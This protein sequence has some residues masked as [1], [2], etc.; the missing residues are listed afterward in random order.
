[1]AQK[2]IKRTN[3]R[4]RRTAALSVV[5]ADGPTTAADRFSPEANYWMAGQSFTRLIRRSKKLVPVVLAAATLTGVIWL[6]PT[7]AETLR[8]QAIAPTV[9]GSQTPLPAA[10][11]GAPGD[12]MQPLAT[13]VWDGGGTTASWSECANW[14]TDTCPIADDIIVFD[15]S[16]GGTPNDDSTWDSAFSVSQIASITVSTY[17]GLLTFTKTPVTITGAFSDT[18][19][20]GFTLTGSVAVTV[21][22]AFTLTTSVTFTANT[23]TLTLTGTGNFDSA[24]TFN[25]ITVDSTTNDKTVTTVNN[26]PS[27]K[28]ALTVGAGDTLSIGSGL[29]ITST[30]VA[31]VTING[32]ISGAGTL[33]VQNSSLGAGGTLSSVVRFDATSGSINMPARTS[34]NGYGGTV[35]IYNNSGTSNRTVTMASGTHDIAGSLLLRAESASWRAI[36]SGANNPTVNVVGDLDY[37]GVGAGDEQISSTGTGT[38]TISGSVDVTGGIS[39]TVT[40]NNIFVMNGASKTLNAVGTAFYDLTLSGT[41]SCGASG[42]TT[43]TRNLTLSGTVTCTR[44]FRM[45]GTANLIG[46]GNTITE[47]QIRG[48]NITVS[49]ITSD[50]TATNFS[51]GTAADGDTDVFDIGSGRTFTTATSNPMT[52]SDDSITGAGIM[53][54]TN[55][56]GFGANGTVSVDY[57]QN[58]TNASASQVG[59]TFGG[60]YE[61]YNSHATTARSCTFGTAGGQTMTIQG[62][63]TLQATSGGDVSVT[64]TV[65]NPTVAITGTIDYTGPAGGNDESISTGTGAWSA[66]GV[67][68]RDGLFT[69]TAGNTLT[70]NGTAN[71]LWCNGRTF[72]NLTI[73]PSSTGTITLQD[74]G[75]IANAVLTVATD[76]TF[77]LANGVLFYLLSAGGSLALNGTIGGGGALVYYPSA[78]FPATG[79]I[80]ST[81]YMSADLASQS[82][83][84]RTYGGPVMLY[85]TDVTVRT[86][87]LG[88]GAGQTLTFSS[89]VTID[90]EGAGALSIAGSTYNPTVNITGNL[91]FTASGLPQSLTTGSGTW[92]VSGDVNFTNATTVTVSP[93]NTLVMNGIGKTLTSAGVTLRSLTLSG[94]ITLANATHTVLEHLSLAGGTITAGSSTVAMTGGGTTITGGGATLN[95]L[96]INVEPGEAVTLQTSDLTVSGTLNVT[97]SNTLTVSSGRTLTLSGNSGTTLNLNTSG[98]VSGAGRLTYQ[99]SATTL[100]TTGTLSSIVRFD[101][102]NGAL[103]MPN[104]TFGGA[105]EIFNGTASDRTV[106][107][108]AGTHTL[109]SALSLLANGTGNV[110]LAGA[111]NN[112]TVN[113]TG[114]LDFT[115]TGGGTEGVTSGTGTWTVAGNV[116]FTGG[117]FTGTTGNTV[118]MIGTSN[119]LVGAGQTLANLTVNPSSAG[120]ITVAT[121]DVTVSG[122]LTVAADDTLSID[123]GRTLTHTGGS[124]S[125]SGTASGAGTLRF[126][127][128]SVGPGTGGTLSSIVRFDATDGDVGASTVDVRTY[129][130]RVELYSGSSTARTIT[131]ASGTYT[132]SSHL[133]LVADGASPGTLSVTGVANNPTLTLA[134]D[135]DFTGTGAASEAVAT[136]TGTWTVSGD[137][138][139]TGGT[140]TATSGHTLALNGTGKTFT[141]SGQAVHHLTVSGGS[142]SLGGTT[143]VNGNLTLSGGTFTSGI[144]AMSVAG[145]GSLVGGSYTLGSGTQTFTGLLT[146]TSGTLA[147]GT[148]TLA[149]NGGL[150]VSGGTVVG[151]TGAIDVNGTFTVSNGAFTAPAASGSFTVSGSFVHSGGTF[152]ANAGTVTLDGADQTVSGSTTFVNLTKTV[153]TARTLTFPAAAT[154][155]ITGTLT[156]QGAAGALLSLRSSLTGTQWR[157]DPQG[158]R[159]LDYLDVKDSNNVNG[160]GITT[161]GHHMTNSGN[162]TG[163]LF[164]PIAPSDLVG[165]ALSS[166]SVRWTWTDNS[167][168]ETG[169]RVQNTGGTTVASAGAGETA[170]TETGL[171]RG[172]SYTRTVVAYNANGESSA[173]AS[174]TVTTNATLPS[175]PALLAPIGGAVVGTLAPSF[176]FTRSTDSDDGIGSY[177]LLFDGAA[178]TIS[179]DDPAVGSTVTLSDASAVGAASDITVTLSTA[180]LLTEGSHTWA[181]RVTDA[182][183]NVRESVAESFVLDVTK[184]T[185]GSL[186][187]TPTGGRAQTGDTFTATV[188]T[189]TV[190]AAFTDNLALGSAVFLLEKRQ[191]LLGIEIG[192]TTE[193]TTSQTL[194]GTTDSATF[195]V[196]DALDFGQYLLTVTADDAA[197]NEIVS[198]RALALAPPGSVA[199]VVPVESES[200]ETG[201]AGETSTPEKTAAEV[202]EEAIES[203]ET[204]VKT[205][206]D[207]TLPSLEKFAEYRRVK[208]SGNLLAFL[209]W[210][211]PDG[212]LD[213]LDRSLARTFATFRG[214]VFAA[215]RGI[216]RA[217]GFT[218]T[219]L[220]SVRSLLAVPTATCPP[221]C[222]PT[223]REPLLAALD[224]GLPKLTGQLVVWWQD[225]RDQALDWLVAGRRNRSELASSNERRLNRLF[226]PVAVV[227]RWVGI[228]AR[229][230]VEG[231]RGRY[232]EPLAI[233][234]VAITDV[235]PSHATISWRTNRLTRGK[236]NWGY[237]ISYGADGQGGSVVVDQFATEHEVTLESLAPQTKYYFEIVVTDLNEQQTYDAYYGFTTP[238]E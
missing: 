67:D 55:S 74:D 21:G 84:A 63:L 61:C 116:D 137:V 210:L 182:G 64:G 27:V 107:M 113:V 108:S 141:P 235:L 16:A 133:Y 171:T 200:G 89:N 104:R 143:T 111:A 122:T 238:A 12:P 128:S 180:T 36:L 161:V 60:D 88:T 78:T 99:N 139:L 197:G 68:F 205:P 204:V 218:A 71:N 20:N 92:T 86:I 59:R 5:Y 9:L 127:S 75:C 215:G 123:T 106:T 69:A 230:A 168:D 231:I 167:T 155:T 93:L 176:T 183:G 52:A 39:P 134:G 8:E 120:T 214:W 34:P 22:G 154:Q 114:D 98:T 169:F 223:D 29:T 58:V 14:D 57:R 196:T 121:S 80:T 130:G 94:S 26:S 163:W 65:Q 7:L 44:Y 81:L 49:L 96:T 48:V 227:G 165:T 83:S 220:A 234:D 193:T 100:P 146:V 189:F 150:T 90:N 132:F 177:Q 72:V 97:D 160:T 140:F 76:D 201:E 199:V 179:F 148:G 156:L 56:S 232:A 136:G 151:S 233:T 229:V 187:F 1:M 159:T 118:A 152:T 30:L 25:N 2:V 43:V 4:A 138:T 135:L 47:L 6:A 211:L 188:Q 178:S 95:N 158:T 103:T 195:A 173:S 162:N 226:E 129:G 181:V 85:N 222:E 11:A 46:G 13:R 70:L 87:T 110:T 228:G 35:E 42:D 212:F 10:P 194:E 119:Q 54:N 221:A 164:V 102:L 38:W 28:A 24:K 131:L 32:T 202:R 91:T 186:S 192:R 31:S 208:E 19:T 79:T 41:I 175:A 209:E 109:S 145:T 77:S 191:F 105:V 198:T 82:L 219:Q 115:G 126:T 51:L 66:A 40:A 37:T 33:V 17:S 101:A 236:V 190:G 124:V 125:L 184:P 53:A 15:G 217:A 216:A 23:S 203:G 149:A 73:D 18:S 153:T 62:N 237:S 207:L 3:R 225:T 157:F 213:R 174:F 45:T 50:L 170:V 185:L 117:T 112:P 224:R 142:V 166:T 144:H 206:T 147:H 172:T